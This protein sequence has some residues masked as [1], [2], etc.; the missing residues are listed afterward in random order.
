MTK[1]TSPIKNL[2]PRLIPILKNRHEKVQDNCI[3]L[4][5]RIVDRGAEFVSE[6][7]L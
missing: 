4:V 6:E 5:G 7:L 3:N 2:L 1:M